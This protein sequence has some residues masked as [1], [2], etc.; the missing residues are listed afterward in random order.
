MG[1]YTIYDMAQITIYL[2]DE[3]ER[4]ARRAARSQRV[5]VSKWIAAQIRAAVM[6]AWP[7]E[8]LDAAGAIPD[9]PSLEELRAATG[10]DAPREPL[11]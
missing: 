7:R 1:S 5:S 10:Q 8:V 6:E 11:T 4:Q 9:F 3:L 2:P